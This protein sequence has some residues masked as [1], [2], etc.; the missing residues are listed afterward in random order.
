MLKA[1]ILEDP[2]ED[3]GLWELYQNL[4]EYMRC[5]GPEAAPIL[6]E[7][8]ETNFLVNVASLVVLYRWQKG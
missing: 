8:I 6:L 4:G 3:F 1:A 2:P 7:G 5:C